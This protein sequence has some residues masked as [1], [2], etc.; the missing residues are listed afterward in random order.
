MP[1]PDNPA[2]CRVN[3]RD[4]RFVVHL[5]RGQAFKMLT[6]ITCDAARAAEFLEPDRAVRSDMKRVLSVR[7]QAVRWREMNDVRP[8]DAPQILILSDRPDPALVV[9]SK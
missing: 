1:K 4:E 2:R 6:I 9:H 3:G 8:L 7:R 5:F